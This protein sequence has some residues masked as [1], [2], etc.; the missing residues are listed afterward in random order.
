MLYKVYRHPSGNAI[1]L[2]LWTTT[3]VTHYTQ[4]QVDQIVN[5]YKTEVPAHWSMHEWVEVPPKFMDYRWIISLY[6]SKRITL[7]TPHT[8]K[9]SKVTF[10]ETDEDV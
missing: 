2:V 9:H 8:L 7:R 4:G 10:H 1:Q 5:E 3:Q 6:D